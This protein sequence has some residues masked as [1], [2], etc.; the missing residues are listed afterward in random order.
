MRNSLILDLLKMV[1]RV[2]R[3]MYQLESW[4]R[5]DMLRLNM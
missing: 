4:E 5:M 3:L 2:I 1:L